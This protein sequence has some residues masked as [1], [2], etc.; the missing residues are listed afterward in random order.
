MS[1]VLVMIALWAGLLG[2]T[3]Q[4]AQ[5]QGRSPAFWAIVGGAIG[6][7]GF[8]FG[9]VLIQRTL[10]LGTSTGVMLLSLL[11]PLLLMIVTMTGVVVMLKRSPVHVTNA[12]TWN[13]HFVDRGEGKVRFRGGGK[14]AFEW[15]DGA[16]DAELRDVRA[17]ADGE[18]VRA[19]I[20]DDELCFMPLGKP[21]TQ[22]GRRQQSVQLARMLGQ[23]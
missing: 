5:T 8:V 17:E 13:V 14:V 23:R 1:G 4:V 15:R 9:L 3:G 21:D 11:A 18:C 20:E 10:D 6:A 22:A 7:A 12:K 16:R 19:K 2:W